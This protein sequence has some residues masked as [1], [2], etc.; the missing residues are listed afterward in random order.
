MLPF[1]VTYYPDQWPKETWDRTFKKISQAGLNIVRFGEMAW[2]WFE[3]EPGQFNFKGLDLAMDLCA[4]HGLKVLLGIPTSQVPTWFF[5]KHPNSQ[6]V[7]QDGT[8]YPEYGP[9]PN[10]CKDNPHYR[11]LAE[12]L[13]RKLVSRYK[14]HPALHAWQVDNEPV[15]PPLDHTTTNDYCHCEH[16]RQAFI[17]WAKKKYKTIKHLNQVWGTRFWTTTF[18]RF[19][20][21]RTP[22][23]GIWEA[24]SPH[25]FLDWFRFK[26]DSIK[27]WVSHLARITRQIDKKH[28]IGT[29]G[30]IGICTR[31]PDHSI[32][33]D[34]LDFYGLD[35]YPKGGRMSPRDLAYM[36]DLWRS[37][38][39]AT[40]SEFHITEMQGG[41][42]VR[43][44]A[45]EHVAGPEIYGWTKMAFQHGAQALL[46][47][48]WKPPLFG[49]E[50]GGFG[51]LKPDGS[52]TKRLETIKKLAKEIRNSK[53]EIR[54]SNIA[55][56]YL[57]A[58]EVQT[59]QEQGPPRGIVGQWEPVRSELGLMHTPQSLS[60]AYQAIYQ[61]GKSVDFIFERDLDSGNLPDKVLLLPNPY[62]I[63]KNQYSK[64]KD[65]IMTGGTLI[66][67]SRFGLK[68]ENGHL[69]PNPLLEDLL[70]V[71]HEY[72]EPTRRGFFD[73]L[74]GKA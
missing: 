55:I 18:S 31:V 49:A 56:A 6:P 64:L 60:G 65:W 27:D 25:I 33:A 17:I 12:R 29:N 72:T 51:I 40:K 66:T 46:Y 61:K 57:H 38:C 42:N 9:R 23:A 59:Y 35:I 73:G 45:P 36:C 19:E 58:S 53:L 20:D 22:K 21:I 3:P 39:R 67:E 5:R 71:V 1:G 43:W 13:T 26:T 47:H 50:T 44:G 63:S 32:I 48:N 15:Y 69:Y 54:N 41:Q 8:R 2:D 10:I 34:E 70:G 7:A 28:Q 68:D 11:K 4:K 30:F 52:S 16:T 62:L 74:K 14:N 24:V 37:F